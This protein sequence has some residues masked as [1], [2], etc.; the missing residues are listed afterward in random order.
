MTE[1]TNGRTKI[2]LQT[3]FAGCVVVVTVGAAWM[4]ASLAP[5]RIQQ[6]WSERVSE[7]RQE[8]QTTKL[9]EIETQFHAK[10]EI[11]KIQFAQQERLNA[12]YWYQA[13]GYAYPTIQ[14]FPSVAK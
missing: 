9:Q 3:V 4:N 6:E 2:N 11:N 8:V 10:D 14:Y 13:F 1:E 7:L 12:I 5:V